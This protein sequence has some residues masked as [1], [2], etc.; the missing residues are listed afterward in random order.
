MAR[1]FVLFLCLALT[2][3][4]CARLA[5]SRL[6]PVNW[7]GNPVAVA[8]TD[9]SGNLRPLVPAG[10]RAAPADGRVMI[11]TV[12][13]V[14]IDRTAGGA[15]I[16]ATG[17]APTQGYFNAQLVP[18]GQDGGVLRLEF[19]VEAPTGTQPVGSAASRTITVARSLR[20]EEIAIVRT[21]VVIG[22][23]GGRSISR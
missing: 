20:A 2:L 18:V 11:G 9:L 3:A 23:D 5:G 12:S 4:G 15:I 10:V 13:D 21:I 6:N 19:R 7:F 17:L 1:P 14:V 16:R 22:A 8:P